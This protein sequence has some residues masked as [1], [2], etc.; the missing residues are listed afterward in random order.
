MDL[1]CIRQTVGVQVTISNVC[2]TMYSPE[3]EFD[4]QDLQAVLETVN[5]HI[6]LTGDFDSHYIFCGSCHLDN[7]GLAFSPRLVPDLE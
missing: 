6:I 7:E 5:N 1:D 2:Y 3:T 4:S